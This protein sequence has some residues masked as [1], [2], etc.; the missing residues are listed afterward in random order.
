MTNQIPL[1][2]RKK[3]NDFFSPKI[4]LINDFWKTPNESLDKMTPYD[5]FIEYGIN[6]MESI[7]EDAIN[8]FY[9]DNLK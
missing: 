7:L 9:L 3:V 2:I 5:F 4:S 8:S 6:S 1:H